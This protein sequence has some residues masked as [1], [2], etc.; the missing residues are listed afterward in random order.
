MLYGLV[1]WRSYAPV[2]STFYVLILIMNKWLHVIV[3]NWV[4]YL[5][6]V[7]FL[8]SIDALCS[9]IV[10]KFSRICL[11]LC[12]SLWRDFEDSWQFWLIC[13]MFKKYYS[14]DVE[15]TVDF[16]DL[17]AHL[18]MHV[19]CVL[20]EPVYHVHCLYEGTDLPACKVKHLWS[21]FGCVDGGVA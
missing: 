15:V 17:A 16:W 7:V 18:H 5:L 8:H 2:I 6:N 20:I 9:I 13:V 1:T 10:K 4:Y 3:I 19:N 12:V 14:A 11:C 21:R